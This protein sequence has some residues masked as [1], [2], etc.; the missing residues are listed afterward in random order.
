MKSILFIVRLGKRFDTTLLF[1]SIAMLLSML[2]L[3]EIVVRYK[4][5]DVTFTPFIRNNSI[6]DSSS[7]SS[8]EDDDEDHH[9]TS[10]AIQRIDLKWFQR[11]FW[12]WKNY[13]DYIN[14]LL[15]FTSV[16]GIL[17][18]FLHRF[19]T[20]IEILGFLSLGLESTLPLPQL[21]TNFKHRTTEGFS[22]LILASWVSDTI[23]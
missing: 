12:S 16:V 6:D 4:P 18:I 14:C 9:H 22:L 20:F 5:N 19:D 1:Q 2:I 13:L 15:S 8:D 3:L 11:S 10:Q 23:L 17:Y 7:S 21:L